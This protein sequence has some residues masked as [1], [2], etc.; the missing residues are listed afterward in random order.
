MSDLEEK[1]KTSIILKKRKIG[2]ENF[3]SSYKEKKSLNFKNFKKP[4]KNLKIIV[5]VLLFLFS[6]TL[7][8]GLATVVAVYNWVAKEL[9]DPNSIN[10]IVDIRTSYIRDRNGNLLSEVFNED[11]KRTPVEFENMPQD[12]RDAVVAVEDKRFYEHSGVD[13]VGLARVFVKNATTEDVQGAS[14]LTMQLVRNVLLTDEKNVR[15]GVAGYKRKLKEIILALEIEREFSKD[16]ILRMYLNEIPFGSIAW[17]VGAA[18]ELYFGKETKDLNLPESATLA[19]LIQAPNTYSPYGSGKVLLFARRNE[20]LKMMFDQKKISKDEYEASIIVPILSPEEVLSEESKNQI[21]S[22]RDK[23]ILE[24]FAKGEI[25]EEQKNSGLAT[26]LISPDGKIQPNFIKNIFSPTQIVERTNKILA[27]HFVYFIKEK[28]GEKLG[29]KEFVEGGYTVITTLHLPYQQM[30]EQ[31]LKDHEQDAIKAAGA[32]N[33]AIVSID[34]RNGEVLAM[35][36]SLDY[37]RPEIDGQ[38]NVATAFRQM[39]SSF[40]PYV[41]ASAWKKGY[42]PDSYIYDVITEFPGWPK[43]KPPTNFNKSQETGPIQMKTALTNSLNIPAIKTMYL[44]GVNDTMKLVHDLGAESVDLELNKA[45]VP[46]GL[47]EA[48]GSEELTLLEHTFAFSTIMN[49]GEKNYIEVSKNGKILKEPIYILKIIDK[50]GVVIFDAEKERKKEQVLETTIARYVTTVLSEKSLRPSWSSTLYPYPNGKWRRAAVKTGTTNDSKDIVVMGSVPQ[51]ATGVWV[52]NTDNTPLKYNADASSYTSKIWKDYMSRALAGSEDIP[53][54]IAEKTIDGSCYGTNKIMANGKSPFDEKS[55]KEVVIDT[56]SGFLATEL[57]P[58]NFKE[59]RKY[60]EAKSILSFINPDAEFPCK[61]NENG[62][63]NPEFK[64]WQEAIEKW[65]EKNKDK[66][67]FKNKLP[68]GVF[69]GKPPKEFDNIHTLENK[70]KI[71]IS[72]PIINEEI[73]N[74]SL[75]VN[76]EI[77]A[78]YEISKINYYISEEL[79]GTSGDLNSKILDLTGISNGTK[80]L[81]ITAFDIY[82]NEDSAT[83][84]IK[85]NLPEPKTYSISEISSISE[86][87]FSET[88][89]PKT[90]QIEA[91][92]SEDVSA[93][94]LKFS[95][96]GVEK[97]VTKSESIFSYEILSSDI[98]VGNNEVIATATFED[99]HEEVL[100]VRF[101]VS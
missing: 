27:P 28:L 67:N 18:S 21:K 92:D 13:P 44:A 61:S 39:G 34:P 43:N 9:P 94:N 89:F 33:G 16:E 15:S 91:K 86:K 42:V 75:E 47:A 97:I 38:F 40:K 79:V 63:K 36:G 12:L 73:F 98:L 101:I 31:T 68:E 50:N 51:L 56:A 8:S 85:I 88:D 17:G 60:F 96:N 23:R 77:I 30:A 72:S 7:I 58:E 100:N 59:T 11:I 46:H 62:E 25:S 81:K 49:D 14:T 35:V 41:Y 22:L 93:I 32:N 37:Y 24:M 3:T 80:I 10:N 1:T 78:N 6:F 69:L 76:F 26:E 29:E 52:G 65:Y 20:V 84:E 82:E 87:T 99:S 48:I 83:V 55:L 19:A 74:P 5:I 71:T 53:F 90:I 4:K 57:T 70:P 45:G 2:M 54:K 64:K 66:E 95:I